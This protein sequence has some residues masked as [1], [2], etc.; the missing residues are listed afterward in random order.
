MVCPS[1]PHC[2]GLQQV[3]TPFSGS[4]LQSDLIHSINQ[5]ENSLDV[6]SPTN[7][8]VLPLIVITA[9]IH[10]FFLCCTEIPGLLAHSAHPPNTCTCIS[11]VSKGFAYLNK[12]PLIT[13]Y[14]C[15]QFYSPFIEQMFTYFFSTLNFTSWKQGIPLTF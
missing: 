14:P 15:K 9:S 2:H 4:L 13:F 10:L 3:P 5:I 8:P 12:I 1:F 6:F 7:S 11:T